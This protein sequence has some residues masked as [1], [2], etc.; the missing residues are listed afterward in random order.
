MPSKRPKSIGGYL[1]HATSPCWGLRLTMNCIGSSKSISPSKNLSTLLT[2][3]DHVADWRSVLLALSIS[4]SAVAY[5]VVF[6]R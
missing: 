6:V 4:L 1:Q 2:D 3:R 5:A